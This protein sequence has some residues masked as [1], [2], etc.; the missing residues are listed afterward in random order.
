MVYSWYL[1]SWLNSIRQASP[2]G[3]HRQL[4]TLQQSSRW[5]GV[6]LATW[7]A[8]NYGEKPTATPFPLVVPKP[9]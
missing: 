4:G 1:V 5:A 8:W 3:R 9:F 2:G 7:D 6:G